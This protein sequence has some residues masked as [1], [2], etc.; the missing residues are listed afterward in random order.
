MSFFSPAY[1]TWHDFFKTSMLYPISKLHYFLWMNN[2]P[3]YVYTTFS[4]IH[5]FVDRSFGS[6]DIQVYVGVP[7]SVPLVIN[8][9]VELLDHMVVLYLAFWGTIFHSGNC[10]H[11]FTFSPA[12][13]IIQQFL[14]ILA[15]TC[16]FCFFIII[17]IAIL[18]VVSHCSFYLHLPNHWWCWRSS[19]AY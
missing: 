16:F 5:S 6:T 19:C 11:Q 18:V 17:V 13:Y 4:F 9:G 3:F 8:L 7:L 10:L 15:N 14:Y 12:M 1:F 2:T